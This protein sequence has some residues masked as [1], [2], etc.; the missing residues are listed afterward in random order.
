MIEGFVTFTEPLQKIF[1][2]DNL[3]AIA[4]L[5]VIVFIVGLVTID[6]GF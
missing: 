1:L 3:F 6:C 2:T 4:D 5:S